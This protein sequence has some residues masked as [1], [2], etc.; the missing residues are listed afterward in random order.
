MATAENAEVVPGSARILRAK[1]DTQSTL[2]AGSVRSQEKILTRLRRIFG[3]AVQ[4]GQNFASWRAQVRSSAFRL[5][6]AG[7]V[8]SKRARVQRMAVRYGAPSLFITHQL[9]SL[10]G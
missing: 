4:N 3:V 5:H 6:W 8:N 2:E 10:R 7:Q 1:V 9:S